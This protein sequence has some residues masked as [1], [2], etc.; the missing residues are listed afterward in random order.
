VL[1]KSEKLFVK[2][3]S[4]VGVRG[5]NEKLLNFREIAT[6]LSETKCKID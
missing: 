4:L 3:V 1:E 6:N 2:G 5:K